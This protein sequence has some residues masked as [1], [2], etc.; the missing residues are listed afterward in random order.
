[1]MEALTKTLDSSLVPDSWSAVG[2]VHHRVTARH[3][4][5]LPADIL[6]SVRHRDLPPAVARGLRHSEVVSNVPFDGAVVKS[7]T[8]GDRLGVEV[9]GDLNYLINIIQ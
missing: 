3:P 7:L 1:M 5:G 6:R 9:T 8:R 2:P 4:P